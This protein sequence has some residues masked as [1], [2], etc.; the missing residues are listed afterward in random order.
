MEM[1]FRIMTVQ[2]LTEAAEAAWVPQREYQNTL[3]VQLV[4]VHICRMCQFIHR[5]TR[6][7]PV[8]ANRMSLELQKS[9]HTA[10]LESLKQER[11]MKSITPIFRKDPTLTHQCTNWRLVML[12]VWA[13]NPLIITP[14][15]VYF[16]KALLQGI[17]AISTVQHAN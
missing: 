16:V 6:Q 10:V 4:K 15:Q 7:D 2:D 17:Y 13:R 9:T 3:V 11:R 12:T 14:A 1:A 5:K 8:A